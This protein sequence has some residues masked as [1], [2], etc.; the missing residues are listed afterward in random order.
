MRLAE[1]S[2]CIKLPDLQGWSNIGLAGCGMGHKIDAGC[3]IREIL[4]RDT[5]RKYLDGIG[6]RSFQ[7]GGCW[8]VDSWSLI[9]GCGI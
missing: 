4:G 7:L 5:G 1:V 9:A 3:G 2:F 6:M 8:I